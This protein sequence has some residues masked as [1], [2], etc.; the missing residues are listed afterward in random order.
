MYP[1]ILTLTGSSERKRHFNLSNISS[2][3]E[4]YEN[5]TSN[6]L[7]YVHGSDTPLMI[8]ETTEQITSMLSRIRAI[9]MGISESGS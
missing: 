4:D 7:V 1:V 9:F 5:K 8:K 2:W 3:G 6:T